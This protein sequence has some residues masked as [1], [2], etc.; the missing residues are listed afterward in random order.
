MQNSKS[1]KNKRANLGWD[2][3]AEHEQS[4]KPEFCT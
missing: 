1:N 3:E 4:S 2:Q